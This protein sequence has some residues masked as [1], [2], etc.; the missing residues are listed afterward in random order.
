MAD[1]AS[2]EVGP[3]TTG[4][5]EAMGPEPTLDEGRVGMVADTGVDA[6]G[7]VGWLDAEGGTGA[8]STRCS[9]DSQ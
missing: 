2:G 8:E 3:A 5:G 1:K 9:E 6:T 7:G 4:R